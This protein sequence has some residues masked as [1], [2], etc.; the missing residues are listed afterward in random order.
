M[1]KQYLYIY[2]LQSQIQS[3]EVASLVYFICPRALL[4][5][6]TYPTLLENITW[7][8]PHLMLLLAVGRQPYS[9]SFHW[10]SLLD[11]E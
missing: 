10:V 7:I 4:T 9:A 11:E 2:L 8:L 6:R 1:L 5:L 3:L